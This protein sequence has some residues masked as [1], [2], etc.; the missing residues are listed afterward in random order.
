MKKMKQHASFLDAQLTGK[1]KL[2]NR[3]KKQHRKKKEH[4]AIHAV[5][6]KMPTEGAWMREYE[7]SEKKR[8]K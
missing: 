2:Y 5:L 8:K 4:T 6:K 1:N 7:R 3:V